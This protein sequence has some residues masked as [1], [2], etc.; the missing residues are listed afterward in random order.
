MA[1][2]YYVATSRGSG[3]IGVLTEQE[4]R[5][6]LSAGTL[7][8]GHFCLPTDATGNVSAQWQPLSAAFGHSDPGDS[9]PA[10]DDAPRTVEERPAGL[11]AVGDFLLTFGQIVSL[12]LCACALVTPLV[13]FLEM[14]RGEAWV[15]VPQLVG[16]VAGAAFA[17]LFSA[18]LFVVFTRVKRLPPA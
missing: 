3:I 1:R 9:R 8:P 16:L 11:G 5:H 4:T 15:G 10:D 17:F 18:A 12:F 7:D 14:V 2:H 13:A 6:R